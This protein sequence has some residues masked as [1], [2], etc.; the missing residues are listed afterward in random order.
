M[1]P[2]A[3]APVCSVDAVARLERMTV[4]AGSA[5]ARYSAGFV[6][7]MVHARVRAGEAARA[8]GP[9]ILDF[10]SNSKNEVVG[11]FLET[12]VRHSR[13]ATNKRSRPA[14]LMVALAKGVLADDDTPEWAVAWASARAIQCG[15]AD[16]GAPPYAARRRLQGERAAHVVNRGHDPGQRCPGRGGR[17]PQHCR[18]ELESFLQGHLLVVGGQGGDSHVIPRPLGGHVMSS[19]KTP[20]AYSPAM[21]SRPPC[22]A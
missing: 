12:A 8:K 16:N 15:G 22:A 19:E 4:N 9:L 10:I 3:Q 20:R 2:T 11:G 17:R 14:L 5:A 18:Q 7:F 6:V 1:D 13:T 21:N